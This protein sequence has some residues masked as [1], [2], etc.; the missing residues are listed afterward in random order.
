MA[1]KRTV[2]G[3]EVRQ[4]RRFIF[5]HGLTSHD[6]PPRLF[7]ITAKKLDKSFTELLSIIA[8]LRMGGQGV[9]QSET[10]TEYVDR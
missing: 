2:T 8:K 5:K 7:A 6:I 1:E 3:K 4:A 10:A 9:G